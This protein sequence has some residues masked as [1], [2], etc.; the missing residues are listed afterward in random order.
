[1]FS[2]CSRPISLCFFSTQVTSIILQNDLHH[3]LQPS[4]PPFYSTIKLQVKLS[5]TRTHFH[6]NRE[7]LQPPCCHLNSKISKKFVEI[8][9]IFPVLSQFSLCKKLN[10]PCFPRLEKLTSKFPVF[11]VPWPP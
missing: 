3:P 2:L 4:F 1:M 7:K 9:K 11:S 5:T 6:V 10:S 8:F